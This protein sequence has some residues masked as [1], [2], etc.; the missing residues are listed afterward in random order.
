MTPRSA[1]ARCRPASPRTTAIPA[2]TDG[3]EVNPKGKQSF[4]LP[5]EESPKLLF[6]SNGVPTEMDSSTKRRL[7]FMPVSDW[8]HEAT[9][10]NNYESN[11]TVKDDFGIDLMQDYTDEQWNLDFALKMQCIQYYLFLSQHNMKMEAP[12]EFVQRRVNSS[13]LTEDFEDWAEIYFSES[14]NLN[15]R[16]ERPSMFGAYMQATGDTHLSATRFKKM[17]VAYLDEH[18]M[19]LNRCDGCDSK[20]RI[21]AMG[22]NGKSVEFFYVSMRHQ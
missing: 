3:L 5:Y 13:L 15:V 16:I 22:Q 4:E 11:H 17:L 6:T 12:E 20:G 14:D 21:I 2:I 1:A 18:G 19:E 8:Y 7:E 10:G 9:K